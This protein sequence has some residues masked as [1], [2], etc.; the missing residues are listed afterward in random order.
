VRRKSRERVAHMA[1][2]PTYIIRR[3]ATLVF[4]RRVPAIAAD[5]YSKPFFC[6]S[7]RKHFISE[8]RWSSPLKVVH[9]LG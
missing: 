6:F 2:H 1:A 5:F 9:Q 8:A 3:G 7:L 4:R